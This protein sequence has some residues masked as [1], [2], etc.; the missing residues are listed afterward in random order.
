MRKKKAVIHICSV[1]TSPWTVYAEKEVE[2][3]LQTEWKDKE[4]KNKYEM[5]EK[6]E[7]KSEVKQERAFHLHVQLKRIYGT[8]SY[9]T[10]E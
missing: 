10:K 2:V 5:K 4:K 9:D 6:L 7:T 1:I 3:K 8:K